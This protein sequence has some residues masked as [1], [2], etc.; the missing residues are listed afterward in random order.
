ME[1]LTSAAVSPPTS[2]RRSTRD[3]SLLRPPPRRHRP[4]LAASSRLPCHRLPALCSLG[5]PPSPVPISGGGRWRRSLVACASSSSSLAG[6]DEGEDEEEAGEGRG[7]G[8][9]DLERALAMDASIPGSSQE[10]VRR[11]SSRAYDMRRNLMQTIDSIS[12]DVLESNPWREDSK[13]V[14]VLAQRDNQLWTMKTR[15]SRSE[16]ERELDLLFSKGRKRGSAIGNKA[17]YS[18]VGTKFHML[19][20]DIR[21]GVLVFEDENDAT[22]YCDLLQGG[23]QGC[24]GIAEL[25]ASSV[26]DIC[27]NMKAL[28]VLFRRGRTPPLPKSLEQNLRARK[29]SLEDQDLM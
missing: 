25:E 13:P 1:A 28:A 18:S 19:V 22:R 17:T 5:L 3:S 15:R 29:R 12:Y 6:G 9:D 24:E 2:T 14:Y 16:V 21:E 8:D 7:V 27:R 26:F 20:E 23:G 4:H 11:V 10:F